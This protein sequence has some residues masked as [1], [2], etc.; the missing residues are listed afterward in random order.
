M[1]RQPLDDPRRRLAIVVVPELEYDDLRITTAGE[2]LLRDDSVAIVT[3]PLESTQLSSL[4]VLDRL[5][6][7]GLLE[8][9]A[10]LLQSPYDPDRYLTPTAATP[11]IARAK[12]L[13]TVEL[14]RRLGASQVR[15]E[16]ITVTSHG[17][18]AK[19]TAE[20]AGQLVGA[21]TGSARSELGT[22]VQR[23]QLSDTFPGGTPDIG[24]ATELL[25]GARLT[26]D[27]NLTALV[28]AR[29]G[30]NQ[31]LARHFHVTTSHE[32]ARVRQRLASI[33]AVP[34]RATGGREGFVAHASVYDFQ[35]E[36]TF[37]VATPEPAGL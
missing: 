36:V 13:A 4:P 20:G 1:N 30:S 37:P 32:S 31:I 34:L 3:W 16:E 22:F 21:Q 19:W 29:T 10:V 35:F 17:E 12:L 2:R 9:G 25:T 14:C 27:D 11:S 7:D 6:G 8:P 18:S 24:A 23:T 33:E 5:D 15:V 28:T 26:S